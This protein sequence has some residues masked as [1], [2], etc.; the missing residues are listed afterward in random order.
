MW[1]TSQ[2]LDLP[3]EDAFGTKWH[4]RVWHANVDDIYTQRIF[5][6]DD[7]KSATGFVEYVA[8]QTMHISRLKQVMA[9]LVKD[10]EFRSRHLRPLLFP[11]ERHYAN[12]RPDDP[13][14]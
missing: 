7:P 1:W 2:N 9:R 8:D 14:H 12:A 3:R 11:I 6:W 10:T 4:F 5:F 13:K